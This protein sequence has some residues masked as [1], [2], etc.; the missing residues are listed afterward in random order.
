[1]RE[2]KRTT[3][4]DAAI[5]ELRWSRFADQILRIE[6]RSFPLSL[7]DSRSD[8]KRLIESPTSIGLGVSSGDSEILLGYIAGDLL[9]SFRA[10][11]GVA[12]D[13]HF[14]KRDT[15]YIESLAVDS[16]ARHQGV[17][18]AL[19]RAFLNSAKKNGFTRVTAHVETGS[20][21]KTPFSHRVHKTF[22]NWY[23][24]GRRFDYVEFL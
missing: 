17:G 2:L 18:I 23:G 6:A 22:D 19:T 16:P 5:H 14:G 1:M 21:Q 7:R 15:L 24:T 10:V 9:E 12:S 8:L 20:L 4:D 11:P 3:V 13:P